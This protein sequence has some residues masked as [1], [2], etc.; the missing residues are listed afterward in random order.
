MMK[1]T[2]APLAVMVCERA[3]AADR[4]AGRSGKKPSGLRRSQ[5]KKKSGGGYP[6]GREKE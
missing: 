4:R 2:N 5:L 3:L 6:A 1:K